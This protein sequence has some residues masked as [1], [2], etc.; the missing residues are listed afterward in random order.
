MFFSL[1]LKA[2]RSPTPGQLGA[3]CVKFWLPEAP[4]GVE[5]FVGFFKGLRVDGIEPAGALIAD[6]GESLI[7]QNPQVMRDGRL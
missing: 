2:P 3:E 7:A 6:G 5:P 1:C 4:E